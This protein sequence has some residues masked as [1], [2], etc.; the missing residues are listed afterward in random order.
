MKL[1]VSRTLLGKGGYG[2]VFLGTLNGQQVAVKR[3]Q[4]DDTDPV[5]NEEKVLQ[6]LNHPN[7]VR[8]FY[9]HTD[10]DFK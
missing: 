1:D 6:Q 4:L 5:D 10:D 2:F 3:V 8:L 9:C 7:V